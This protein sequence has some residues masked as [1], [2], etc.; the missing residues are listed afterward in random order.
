MQYIYILYI[1]SSPYRIYSILYNKVIISFLMMTKQ[2][3][4]RRNK[5][6]MLSIFGVSL[7]ATVF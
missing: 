5:S 6:I 4:K 1:Y 2:K 7:V 3:S